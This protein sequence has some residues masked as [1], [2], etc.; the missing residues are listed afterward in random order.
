MTDLLDHQRLAADGFVVLQNFLAEDYLDRIDRKT[1]ATDEQRAGNRRLLDRPWCLELSERIRSDARARSL[2]PADAYAT[3]CTLFAKTPAKNWLVAL[4]QDLTIPVARR[5]ESSACTAWSEKQ[6][7]VF[8][9]P[10]L[11]VLEELVA[12]HVL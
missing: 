6:G 9:Q 10:P 4:H 7:E 11:S 3:Q 8:V 2:L 12:R 5:I 1:Q